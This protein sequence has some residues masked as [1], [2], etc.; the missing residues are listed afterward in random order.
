MRTVSAFVRVLVWGLTLSV[1]AAAEQEPRVAFEQVGACS[2]G[3]PC[4]ATIRIAVDGEFHVNE[5]YP[6]KFKGKPSESVVFLGRDAAKPNE[7]SRTTGD[8]TAEGKRAM[9]VQVR[10]KV[11]DKQANLLGT[12]RFAYCDESGDSCYPKD[13]PLSLSVNAR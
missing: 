11:A 9:V 7:F 2:V 12:L 5:E 4:S 6:T 13:L 3:Q 10:F 8:V 1:V